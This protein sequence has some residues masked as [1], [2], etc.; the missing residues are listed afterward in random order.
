MRKTYHDA[1]PSLL[2][3]IK[4]I[5]KHKRMK[6]AQRQQPKLIISTT[7]KFYDASTRTRKS[8]QPLQ[9]RV[10]AKEI[11]ELQRELLALLSVFLRPNWR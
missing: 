1:W 6:R 8:R 5:A 2:L 4:R 11:R 7:V 9:E 3:L 10:K